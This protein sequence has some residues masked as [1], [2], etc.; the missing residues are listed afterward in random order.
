[1]KLTSHFILS[2]FNHLRVSLVQSSPHTGRGG[3]RSPFCERRRPRFTSRIPSLANPSGHGYPFRDSFILE[4]QAIKTNHPWKIPNPVF[5]SNIWEIWVRSS[6]QRPC[7]HCS[8]KDVGRKGDQEPCI[9]HSGS[10]YL[11]SDSS[12]DYYSRIK[13]HERIYLLKCAAPFCNVS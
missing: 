3:G 8:R 1:M 11:S 4:D 10:S 13:L 7:S 2:R 9:V 12:P 6:C 5:W